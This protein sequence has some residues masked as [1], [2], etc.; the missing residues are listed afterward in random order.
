MLRI[1][2]TIAGLPSGVAALMGEACAGSDAILQKAVSLVGEAMD[3]R[4]E[5]VL[6]ANEGTTAVGDSA[7][8][9]SVPPSALTASRYPL[10]LPRLSIA[11][12]EVLRRLMMQ[13]DGG[14]PPRFSGLE[15][16]TCREG[17]VALPGCA[18]ARSG[19]QPR[20]ER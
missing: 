3:S 10:V 2:L 9:T 20:G 15:R 12:R 13:L 4:L 19:M 17:A 5:S 16:V 14:T 6:S 7:V 18:V 8:G 11:D 1:G